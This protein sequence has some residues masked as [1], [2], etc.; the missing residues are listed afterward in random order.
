MPSG[1]RSTHLGGTRGRDAGHAKAEPQLQD[2]LRVGSALSVKIFLVRINSSHL[3]FKEVDVV[4]WL[5]FLDY[6]ALKLICHIGNKRMQ[7]LFYGASE[8]DIFKI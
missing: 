3:I 8:G 4:I 1:C 5:S 2:A 6:V 7:K